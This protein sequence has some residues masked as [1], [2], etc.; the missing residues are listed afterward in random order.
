MQA[1]FEPLVQGFTRAPYDDV[2]AIEKIARNNS[3][4]AA[5]MVE[6]VLGE[7][8]VV[9]PADDYLERL[10]AIADEQGWL[11]ML[12]EVQTGNGRTGRFFAYQHTKVLPDVVTTAKGLGNGVP[13]GVCLARGDA[14]NVLVAGTHGS[15]FGGNPLA[16][17]AALAVLDT[18]EEERLIE[19]A[20][21]LGDRIDGLQVQRQVADVV[22]VDPDAQ[23]RQ[24]RQQA[25][26]S[27]RRGG[28]L[29]PLA[30]GPSRPVAQQRGRDEAR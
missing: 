11:L 21:E 19:R 27:G 4:V 16:C 10:R 22:S 29:R 12:D 20:A 15:T 25:S 9:I 7:G 2:E 8:G 5:I 28:C 24:L 14:A 17:A 3:N 18:L 1:G 13:I 6:P 30:G 23:H 26:R